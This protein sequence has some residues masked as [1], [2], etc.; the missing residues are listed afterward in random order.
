VLVGVGSRRRLGDELF[1][2]GRRAH[3]HARL[4]LLQRYGTRQR[5]EQ[6]PDTIRDAILTCAQMLTKVSS[7]YR[8]EPNTKKGG[9]KKGYALSQSVSREEENE[10]QGAYIQCAQLFLTSAETKGWE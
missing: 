5:L 9:K 8:T 3:G 2:G 4:R 10:V 6:V 1:A 7:I